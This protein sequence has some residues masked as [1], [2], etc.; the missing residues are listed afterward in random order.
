MTKKVIYQTRNNIAIIAMNTPPVNSLG[1]EM[2]TALH[3]ALQ[4]A[5]A[6]D[7]IEAVILTS[8]T[9][10]CG[11]A[12]ISEFGSDLPWQAPNVPTICDLLDNSKKLVVAAIRKTAL[13]GGLELAM[14]C[15]YRIAT[16][17][18][19][20]GLP[21]VKLGLLP[22]G[23]GTQRLPRITSVELALQ[24]IT[25]GKPIAATE[26]LQSG[27]IDQVTSSTGNLVDSAI[28]YTQ[29]LL[30]T[31][32][33]LRPCDKIDVDTNHLSPDFFDEYKAEI[34]AKTKDQLAPECCVKAI[35]YACQSPLAEGLLKEQQLFN[36]CI[37]SPQG[38]A[39][40]HLFF[41]EREV[42]KIPNVDVK[43]KAR[44][45]KSV[46]VIGAGTM[47]A[48]IAMNFINAGIPVTLLEVKED[49][50]ERGLAL[51]RKN[52]AA[53]ARKGRITEAQVEERM[54]LLQ[55]TLNYDDL[56]DVDLVIEAVFESMAV[57]HQVFSKL[58]EVCKPGAIL[59]TNTST[60][61]VNDIANITKRPQ[62]VI[63]LHFFSPANVMRLLEIVRG[64][65]TADD[66]IA[67]GLKIAKVIRKIPVVV[68]VCFGFVGNRMLEP[69]AR[70]AH[71]LVL[72]GA[73]PVQ[74]DN[75]LT[76]FGLA[77]GV[78]SMYDLAGIDVGFMIREGRRDVIGHDPSYN[79]IS[80]KLYELGRFGQKTGRGF[81]I[82][83]GRD[84]QVD[85]EVD[86]LAI[87]LAQELG[88]ERRKISEQEIFERCIYSLINEGANI[89]S[90]GIAYRSSDC[91]VVWVNGYGFPA[92]RGGPMQY[93]DEIGLD[94][95]LS[96]LN[97]YRNNLGD[98]GEKW[99]KPSSLLEE[100][101]TR[102]KT[103]KEYP[104]HDNA[105]KI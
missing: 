88:I 83:Q 12:D 51:V 96:S 33:P 59:A 14:S 103:F 22:G 105:T 84:K 4:E 7:V 19:I 26:A 87:E 49:A 28:R 55:G 99:F 46:A 40:Q 76:K 95:I 72:E 85:N 57:K 64:E 15:D 30:S 68:G 93:A 91:D 25:S 63:G 34:A 79:K 102:N 74:I 6:D 48:G 8:S 89:L 31:N 27:L 71:R 69:Y 39:L 37:E 62:D 29:S 100:L 18:A 97:E 61:D 81:Y 73:S 10:F 82:Y 23:G 16:D 78:L 11:G 9:L 20:F 21:E 60:L 44:D 94:K 38:R 58:D 2:R 54:S 66:V 101:V 75:V 42:T 104:L 17:D 32:A 53:T 35:E 70:E 36:T 98:Y 56:S 5:L 47:G 90:E 77:I 41:A 43:S 1:L 67:T 45:I 92:Y 52:Y 24:M 50:L 80:D 13:G 86:Q 65:H 3:S